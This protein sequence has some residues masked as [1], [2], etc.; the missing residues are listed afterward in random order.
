MKIFKKILKILGFIFLGIIVLLIIASVV[1]DPIARDFLEDEINQADQGQ[2][3]AQIDN[4][5]V[6][7]LRGNFVIEGISIQTD[8]IQARE[9]ETP[10]IN[11]DAGEISVFGLSWLQFL[12]SDKLQIDRVS[13]LDLVLEAKVRTVENGETDEDTGPFRWEDLD[14]YPMVKDQVDRIRLND[15]NFNNLDLTL[16]NVETIDTLTFEAEEFNVGSDDILIDADRVFTDARAFYASAIDIQGKDVVIN[17][18]GEP[19][20][21]L[22]MGLIEFATRESDF[23]MLSKNLK[24]FKHGETKE[25]TVLFAGYTEFNLTDLDLNRVQEDSLGKIGTV[26]L[27][28]LAIINNLDLNPDAETSD[29]IES[30]PFDFSK[31]SLA[32]Q[33]PELLKSVTITEI[34]LEHINYRQHEDLKIH[35]FSFFTRHMTIDEKPAFANK[36]FLHAEQFEILI[37][38]VQYQGPDNNIKLNLS[39]YKLA[40]E[41]G[42]GRMSM[43]DINANLSLDLTANTK[44]DRFKIT[45]INTQNLVDKVFKIDSIAMVYPRLIAELDNNP[46]DKGADNGSSDAE[47]DLY[48]AIEKVLESLQINTISIQDADIR[49]DGVPGSGKTAL[50]PHMDLTISDIFIAEGTAFKDNR[51]LHTEDISLS[52]KNFE[53]PLPDDIHFVKLRSFGLSTGDGYLNTEGLLFDHIG[54]SKKHLEDPEVDQVYTVSN[55][56]FSIKN[57]NYGSLI[58]EVGFYAGNISMDGLDAEIFGQSLMAEDETEESNGGENESIA[59]FDVNK[60]TLVDYLPEGLDAIYIGAISL[61]DINIL[62]KDKLKLGGLEFEVNQMAVDNRPAFKENRFLHTKKFRIAIDTVGFINEHDRLHLGINDMEFDI[63]QGLGNFTIENLHALHEDR[64]QDQMYINAAIDNFNIK[65]IDTRSLVDR[66]FAIDEI[67]LINPIVRADAG[68]SMD[69]QTEEDIP[70]EEEEMELDLYPFINDFL[71]ELRIHRIAIV[72][73]ELKMLETAGD[74]QIGRLPDINLEV[75]DLLIA[76]GTAFKSNRVMHAIDIDLQMGHIDFPL[77]DEVHRVKLDQFKMSTNKGILS[78]SGLV[79]DFNENYP[80]IMQNQ[81]TNMVF[82]LRNDLFQIE[83]MDFSNV[84]NDINEIDELGILLDKILVDGLDVKVLIDNNFPTQENDNDGA[85]TLQKMIKDIEIPFYLGDLSLKNGHIELKELAEGAEEPGIMTLESLFVNINSLT[86]ID[87]IIGNDLLSFI[88]VDVMLMGNGHFQTKLAIPMHHLE[89]PV[90]FSGEL[91]SL[92]VTTLNRYTEYTSLFGFESGMIYTLLWDF[93]A[94]NEAAEGIFGL[95]YEDLVVRLSESDSPEPAGF[96][97]QVGAYLANVLVIDTDISEHKSDPP[98]KVDFH[99]AKD[100]EEE[101]F[102]EHYIASIIAGLLEI[103]GF[104][105]DIIDP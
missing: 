7:I 28:E 51:I 104:P 15:L 37:D 67:N 57:L 33:L 55:R 68:S 6:S 31:F 38:S 75:T 22:E 45:G 89:Q 20:F 23:G 97:W 62:Q 12:L 25:D 39:D 83:G 41:S 14:I 4:V 65:G 105:L 94:G 98:K 102:M 79:Y 48:P 34:S 101:S 92:D 32:D 35:D 13:F 78:I 99:R 71:E 49:M 70:E 18:T 60:F 43:N 27:N 72:G 80:S 36:Q 84:M 30:D 42:L 85:P 1:I 17:R 50:I 21:N 66:K 52:L 44:I 88:N 47:M 24:F 40:M 103:K 77:P 10:V 46:E 100:D 5:N 8:T 90:R 11:L 29:N 95:S 56:S 64:I 69:Q 59:A 53:I 61:Q 73:A 96:L 9:N 76:E 16:I 54:D 26:F 74:I 3:D 82:S 91:D 2:Y 86:N 87:S 19:Q 93:E 58:R 63:S 81:E